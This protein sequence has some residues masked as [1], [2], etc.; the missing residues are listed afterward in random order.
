MKRSVYIRYT[1]LFCE[2]VEKSLQKIG[3]E[4]DY[5]FVKDDRWDEVD[6]IWKPVTYGVEY[7]LM[8]NLKAFNNF[9]TSHK[10]LTEKLSLIQTG[11]YVYGDAFFLL[12]PIS[13]KC[14]DIP[15]I[16]QD[17][18]GL[19]KYGWLTKPSKN[20]GGKGIE[21]FWDRQDLKQSIS[22]YDNEPR[23][24][25]KYI[26]HP[27]LFQERKFDLRVLVLLTCDKVYYHDS[28]YA[29]VA[30]NK[31][32]P[33]GKALKTHLT[34]ITLNGEEG[35]LYTLP[36][37]QETGVT[38]EKIAKFLTELKPMFVHAQGVEK[39]QR[40]KDNVKFDT[41]E[42]LGVDIMFDKTEN[43]WLLEINKEPAFKSEGFYAEMGPKI[44]GDTLKEAIFFK[45][46]PEQRTPTQFHE[47]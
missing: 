18:V 6:V 40:E 20:F 13:A 10:T 14:P 17:M 35:T 25:Q 19:G 22:K 3:K 9:L 23:V 24:V 26:E 41:F 28:C 34:N 39:L 31:Y 5:D 43:I 16:P 21:I 37:I 30:P 7:K 45:W 11:K 4:F 1:S 29:R 47:F 46:K 2:Q 8:L 32:F 42:L 27:L 15:I 12:H 33:G 36:E 44:I 38:I